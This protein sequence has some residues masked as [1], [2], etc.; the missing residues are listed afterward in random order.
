MNPSQARFNAQLAEKARKRRA[1]FLR[2]HL[3][4]KKKNSATEL[5]KKYGMTHQCMSQMLRRAKQDQVEY[6]EIHAR[7]AEPDGEARVIVTI[8]PIVVVAAQAELV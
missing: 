4:D 8:T 6:R 2:L 5:A 1:M 7:R 3:K